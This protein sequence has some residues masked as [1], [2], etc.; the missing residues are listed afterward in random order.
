MESLSSSLNVWQL[1]GLLELL[2]KKEQTQNSDNG[3]TLKKSNFR[4]LE[5]LRFTSNRELGQDHNNLNPQF[6]QRR[7]LPRR[8]KHPLQPKVG[9]NE[10][11]QPLKETNHH[12][13]HPQLKIPA[14]P[15]HNPRRRGPS[16]TNVLIQIR[17][18]HRLS[19]L[20]GWVHS[21]WIFLR[22][23]LLG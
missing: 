6:R 16:L 9:I 1:K 12:L 7:Q 3:K 10:N 8:K 20:W 17:Q 4:W 18:D 11:R 15:R 22:L 2:S 14:N 21:G 23:L 5:Q 19:I 13:R